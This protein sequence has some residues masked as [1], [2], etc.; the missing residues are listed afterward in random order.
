MYKVLKLDYRISAKE[1]D[2]VYSQF[3]LHHNQKTNI[4]TLIEVFNRNSIF[5]KKLSSKLINGLVNGKLYMP[6]KVEKNVFTSSYELFG[7][8]K[9]IYGYISSE[10]LDT[11]YKWLKER[12]DE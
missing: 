6:S 4:Y 7:K 11:L 5:R 1:D 10:K 9:L 12:I 3:I 8:I 2:Y